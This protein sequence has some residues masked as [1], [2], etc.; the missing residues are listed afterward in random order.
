MKNNNKLP[1]S[2]FR[3]L[4]RA[5][6]SRGLASSVSAIA[7]SADNLPLKNAPFST[8][9]GFTS[10]TKVQM[11]A[12]QRVPFRDHCLPS[13]FVI[14]SKS[15]S[16]PRRVDIPPSLPHPLAELLT[17]AGWS[18]IRLIIVHTCHDDVP[19]LIVVR[20][21]RVQLAQVMYLVE[22]GP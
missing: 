6:K 7:E 2:E 15:R 21:C 12:M 13:L 16:F 1:R 20:R 9:P 8:W 11:F 4:N 10:S 19:V 5:C 22:A 18:V 3:A 14:P 17:D